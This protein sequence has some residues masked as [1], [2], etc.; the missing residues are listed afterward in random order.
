MLRLRIT[1]VIKILKRE[2]FQVGCSLDDLLD[3]SRKHF[4]I[5]RMDDVFYIEDLE[6]KNGTKLNGEEIKGK[7]RKR[8]KDVDG[9]EVGEVLKVRYKL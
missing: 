3:I 5:I 2:D 1:E 6:S 4:K 9:I 8:L 7:G